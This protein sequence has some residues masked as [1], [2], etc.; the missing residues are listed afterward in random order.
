MIWIISDVSLVRDMDGN[1]SHFVSH[2]QDIT[3]RKSLEQ[4]LSYQALHD[5]LTD[6]PNR[7]SLYRHFE[8]VTGQ[9]KTLPQ[10]R[11]GGTSSGSSGGSSSDGRYLAILFLDLDGFKG[12]NDSLGHA[13]GD[14]LLKAVAGRLQGVVRP[15]DTVARLGGDEF[16]VLLAGISGSEEAILIAERLKTSLDAS[17]S[18]TPALDSN[19][20]PATSM[21][22]VSTSIGIAVSELDETERSLDEFLRE[23]DAAMYR[24]KKRG[25]ALY[26]IVELAED[27]EQGA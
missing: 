9:P 17:F 16:C 12:I 5:S 13:A 19:T 7:N 11:R 18:I 22:S 20:G 6:L 14:E 3:G 15:Q 27:T 24:A 4:Q 8:R 23:A 1:P 2:F 21:V 25:G 26:E 10:G